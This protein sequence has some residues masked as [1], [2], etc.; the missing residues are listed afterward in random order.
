MIKPAR[1]PYRD[2]E[3]TVERSQADINRLLA[4][5]GILD[6]QWTTAWSIQKVSLRFITEGKNGK[7]V[8]FEISPP[9]FLA[10]RKTWDAKRGAYQTVEAPNWPQSF[11]ML[12]DYLKAKL[13]AVAYGLR[14]V[15]EEF[16]NDMVVHDELGRETTVGKLVRPAIEGGRIL[17]PQLDQPRDRANVHDAESRVVG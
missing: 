1:A 17:L 9:T 8:A 11:R 13:R 7:K 10:K 16:L 2:T 14:E 4:Q 5:F 3:V 6:T 15:E 12:L